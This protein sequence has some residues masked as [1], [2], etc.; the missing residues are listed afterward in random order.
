MSDFITYQFKTTDETSLFNSEL[1]SL[2]IKYC[3]ENNLILPENFNRTQWQFYSRHTIDGSFEY[4]I[5]FKARLK[6]S[7]DLLREQI[8]HLINRL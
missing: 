8:E 7:D 3:H 6:T 2:I 1:E 4:C 5:A